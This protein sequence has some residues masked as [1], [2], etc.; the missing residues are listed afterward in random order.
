[1]KEATPINSPQAS[2]PHQVVVIEDDPHTCAYLAEAIDAMPELHIIGTAKNCADGSILLRKEPDIALIDLGLPDGSGL[3]IIR[4]GVNQKLKT[5]FVVITVFGDEGH[6]I[7]ALEAGASGYLLK[8]SAMPDIAAL[9]SQVLNGGAPISPI[10]ARKLLLRFR[11]K[12]DTEPSIQL[13]K[14]EFEILNLMAKGYNPQE[15]AGYLHISYHTVVSHVRHIYRKLE[16][17]SRAEAVF[18]ATRMGLINL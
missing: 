17:S 7:P 9:I 18:E 3:D 4:A 16:V 10:I 1:M 8:D 12:N 15:T 13:T 5:Q 2:L 14:R 11:I 6:V